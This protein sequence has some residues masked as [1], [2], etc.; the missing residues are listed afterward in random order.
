[1]QDRAPFEAEPELKCLLCGRLA[2][3]LPVF[4][5]EDRSGEQRKRTYRVER[6]LKA[7]KP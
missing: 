1:M 3:G 4:T 5:D 7:V 2:G 6:R